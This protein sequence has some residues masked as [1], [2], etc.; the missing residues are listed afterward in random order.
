MKYILLAALLLIAF[1]VLSKLTG[2]E[3]RMDRINKYNCAIY[4]YQEDCKTPLPEE[5]RL[6]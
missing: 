1:M 2:Y 6:K 3:E 4:G 5:D